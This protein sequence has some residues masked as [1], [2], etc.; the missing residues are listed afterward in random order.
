VVGER[1]V[2]K[3]GRSGIGKGGWWL[4]ERLADG[5]DAVGMV[6]VFRV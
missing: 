1:V 2:G 3:G 5:V 4:S 6:C